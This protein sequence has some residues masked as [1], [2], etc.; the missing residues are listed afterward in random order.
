MNIFFVLVAVMSLLALLFVVMPLFRKPAP[1]M[2]DQD[3]LNAEIARARMAELELDLGAGRIEQA[4]YDAAREDLEQELLSDLAGNGTGGKPV[5][6]GGW[7]VLLVALAVPVGAILLYKSIG[8]ERII[9]LLEAPPASPRQQQQQQHADQP[10]VEEMINRLAAR[11]ESDP[12][13]LEGWVMLARSYAMTSQYS[14]AVPAFRNILRLG[15]GDSASLL[16]DFAD[17][18]VAS[19]EGRFTDESG[20]LLTRALALEPGNI[21]ALWLAGHW[22]NQS[23]D[24]ATAI[25]YWQQ[26]VQQMTP[27]SHDWQIITAQVEQVRRQAGLPADSMVAADSSQTGTAAPAAALTVNVSLDPALRDSVRPDDTVFIFARAV[28]GPRMPLAIVRKQVSDLPVTVTLDDS[29]A[30]SPAMVLSAFDPV[31][32]GARISRSGNAIPQ[33]G[34]LQGN[35]TPVS[36]QTDARLDILIDTA[37]P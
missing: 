26:A 11:M 22:K 16:A 27:D 9:A 20:A 3:A 21:K 15:G 36:T 30:M 24:A 25:H 13:N 12:D 23:G 19:S 10:S 6:N 7:A 32:I 17:A 14:L 1:G 5:R 34:D 37:I 2:V 31:T 35:K 33:S 8:N 18:L 4:Q 29:M 28:N